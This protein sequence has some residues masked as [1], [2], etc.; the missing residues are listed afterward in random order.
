[1]RGNWPAALVHVFT[2]LGIVCALLATHALLE[3]RWELAFIWL[4]V[5]LVIDAVDGTL[6]RWWM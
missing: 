2:A 6:A 1:M 3:R 4:G 5:A